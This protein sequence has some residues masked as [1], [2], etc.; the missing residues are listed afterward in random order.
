MEEVH[1]GLTGDAAGSGVVLF[2]LVETAL[3]FHRLEEIATAAPV[4]ALVFGGMDLSTQ[5]GGAFSWEPLLYARSRLVL[6]AA[7]AG[8]VAL[9]VPFAGIRDP[10]GLL[11]EARRS[12][13][14]GFAGK[15]AIHP[16]QVGPIHDA[17]TPTIDELERARGIIEADAQAGG[18]AFLLD[19]A[20]VDRPLVLAARRTLA[21]ARRDTPS[22]GAEEPGAKE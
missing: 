11:E 20:M 14:L 1:G 16:A 7:L 4:A 8:I 18:G 15:L 21:L 13:R 10:A 22:D 17:F 6:A 9:D 5:T 19:G 2:P 12:A 3:G